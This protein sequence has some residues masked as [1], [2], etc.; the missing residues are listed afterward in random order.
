MC[1]STSKQL[2][3]KQRYFK[4]SSIQP[5]KTEKAEILKEYSLDQI[6][7]ADES[8]LVFKSLPNTTL[9]TLEER[10]TNSASNSKN[11]KE[12]VTFLSC[13]NASASHALPLVFI[14]KVANP[15]CFQTGGID[16]TTKRKKTLNKTDLPVIYKHSS[17][18]WMT[19]EIFS[20]WFHD[21]FVPSVEKHLVEIGQ[22]PKAVLLLDNCACHPDVLVSKNQNIKVVMLPPNTT[23]IIQPQDQ[24]IIASVKKRFKA[25]V[26]KMYF[27]SYLVNQPDSNPLQTFYNK[28]TIKD[29]I[30]VLASVWKSTPTTT[31]K[32]A[33]H[34]LNINVEVTDIASEPT[35]PYQNVIPRH[36]IESWLQTEEGDEGF[37]LMD[38]AGIIERV[39][40]PERIVDQMEEDEADEEPPVAAGDVN[41]AV[42][43]CTQLSDLIHKIGGSEQVQALFD[44]QVFLRNRQFEAST[45]QSTISFG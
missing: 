3:F 38:S 13:T 42:L 33:W 21:C 9:T 19:T 40:N 27:Q 23:S 7:N 16:R 25:E 29:V 12:R 37:E 44:L 6:Y 10:R 45:Y 8:G 2:P 26:L 20:E 35:L 1:Q 5:P 36:E 22:E 17:N 43:L 28:Y 32:R 30:F 39:R 11:E 24:G 18:A 34:K 14:H 31:L 41:K 15:R 4:E